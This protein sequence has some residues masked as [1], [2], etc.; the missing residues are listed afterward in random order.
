MRSLRIL[1][2]VAA[3]LI[4]GAAQGAYAE[5]IAMKICI[6]N[7]ATCSATITDNGAGDSNGSV[8]QITWISGLGDWT[9]QVNTGT[10]S[11]ILGPATLDLSFNAT[12]TVAG[13]NQQLEI[14]FTQIQTSSPSN[15][16]ALGLGGVLGAGQTVSYSAY[17]DTADTLFSTANQIGSLTFNTSTYSG[18]INGSGPSDGSYTLTQKITSTQ[19]GS[20]GRAQATG[21]ATVTPV[22]E[23]ASI[24]LLGVGLTGLAIRGYRKGKKN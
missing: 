1:L 17:T 2:I 13:S 14:Y 19:S 11:V 22:P 16:F 21:D 23:P 9:L 15:G 5:T 24:V 18:T 6:N 7:G 10:G 8:G 3:V 12:N 20:N 4:V